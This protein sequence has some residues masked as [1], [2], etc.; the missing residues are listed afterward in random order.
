M[1][2]LICTY[3]TASDI[4]A[5]IPLAWALRSAGHEVLYAGGG[6]G[7]RE[8]AKAG[9]PFVDLAPDVDL[10][11]PFRRRAEQTGTS[12]Q[13]VWYRSGVIE[14]AD[15][16]SAV[17]LFGE[18]SDLVAPGA[19]SLARR[20]RP[21]L[22]V[23]TD[24]QG[25]GPLVASLLSVP[26]VPLSALFALVPDMVERLRGAMAATYDHYGVS[27]T[28]R[29]VQPVR[30]TPLSVNPQRSD[31]LLMRHIPY[32][33]S[34]LDVGSLPDWLMRE[35][36]RRRVL[37]T[38]GTFV[39]KYGGLAVLPEL[40]DQLQAVDAEFVLALGDVDQEQIPPVPS[41]VRLEGWLPLNA[42]LGSCSAVVHHGGSGTTLA[43]LCA[44]V[45]QIILAHGAD[46]HFNAH[47]VARRGLGV[48]ADR[49]QL[50]A[51]LIARTLA[52]PELAGTAAEV[53]EE[54]QAMPAPREI[55][56]LLEDVVK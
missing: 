42:V 22:V 55:A 2:I 25:S 37:L 54:I 19:V 38:L 30:T 1:R 50:T 44:G 20:W 5:T 48:A 46:Q 16:G 18:L 17:E 52:S 8:C 27:G 12:G 34:Y 45:P 24:I 21:E 40:M 43:A 23:S 35:P 47:V 53:R 33:G 11:E 56:A 3:S 29:L 51:E 4:F 49:T 26:L 9:F 15:V 6:D 41:N 31:H 32:N 7:M 28:P 10:T 14:E 39:P 13:L 36:E